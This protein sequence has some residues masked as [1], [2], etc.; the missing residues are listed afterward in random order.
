MPI[1]GGGGGTMSPPPP[2]RW[3]RANKVFKMNGEGEENP[4]KDFS[5]AVG[6]VDGPHASLREN[7][8]RWCS[9]MFGEGFGSSLLYST[10]LVLPRASHKEHVEGNLKT[11][12]VELI[13]LA[14]LG[15]TQT[16]CQ[17]EQ[18]EVCWRLLIKT[19][20]RQGLFKNPFRICYSNLSF[21]NLLNTF[22]NLFV[23]L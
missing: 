11:L 9:V 7:C 6:N 10:G 21:E 12:W 1:G 14:H 8:V 4:D 18:E 3:D 23:E 13:K 20:W 22:P 17:L 5:Q 16:W 19:L 15:L 2:P